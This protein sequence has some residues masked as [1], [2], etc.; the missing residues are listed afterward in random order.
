[1]DDM[2]LLSIAEKHFNGDVN[3]AKIWYKKYGINGGSGYP[4]WLRK[5]RRTKIRRNGMAISTTC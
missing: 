5:W 1:M 3:I 2:E 4:S